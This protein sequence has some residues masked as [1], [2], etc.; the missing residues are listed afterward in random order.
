MRVR[1]GRP[2]RRVQPEHLDQRPAGSDGRTAR[3]GRPPGQRPCRCPSRRGRRPAGDP[4][5]ARHIDRAEVDRLRGLPGTRRASV[6]Q[7]S[8]DSEEG[9]LFS[10]HLRR[11]AFGAAS[12]DPSGHV[13][14]LV[15]SMIYASTSASYKLRSPGAFLY[16]LLRTR[17]WRPACSTSS[18]YRWAR[19][20]TACGAPA[21]PSADSGCDAGPPCVQP[22]GE[23]GAA[24][25]ARQVVT[26]HDVAAELAER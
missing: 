7:T 20:R 9:F 14:Q 21:S 18:S 24:H 22:C 23:L 5:E 6:V 15:G 26:L 4:G 17:C 13:R 3:G 10:P 19:S 2:A 11:D 16:S 12:T 25:R 1:A 8:D